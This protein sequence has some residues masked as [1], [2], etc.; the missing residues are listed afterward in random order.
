VGDTAAPTHAIL[1]LEESRMSA[2]L[3]TVWECETTETETFHCPRCDCPR[4]ATRH[5]VRARLLVFGRSTVAIGSPSPYLTCSGCGRSWE[6]RTPGLDGDVDRRPTSEDERALWAV[7]AAVVFSDLS[8]QATE[9][10]MVAQVI[11]R[12]TAESLDELGVD[13]LLRTARSRWG[14]PLVRLRK[15]ACVLDPRAKRRIVGAAYLVCTADREI[16]PQESR[17]LVRIGEAL[18]MSPRAVRA[19]IDEAKANVVPRPHPRFRVAPPVG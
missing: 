17:L 3:E 11:R 18:E 8:V 14:D 13:R 7:V 15:L 19:A 2:F 9:K 6:A 5:S 12:Y 16:H 10:R 4:D 1:A